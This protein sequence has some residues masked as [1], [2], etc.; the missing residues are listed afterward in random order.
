MDS[1]SKFKNIDFVKNP[2][3]I[4]SNMLY[5]IDVSCWYWRYNGAVHKIYNAR[6]DI[7]TLID[8]DKNNVKLITKAVNGGSNGLHERVQLFNKIKKEWGLE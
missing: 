1:Y 5:A 2:D 7:N 4:A 3:L 6:G 8:N